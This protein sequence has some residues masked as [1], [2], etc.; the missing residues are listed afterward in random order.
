[1][2]K[3][4]RIDQPKGKQLDLLAKITGGKY[5]EL[6]IYLDCDPDDD[7][8]TQGGK[9]E[10]FDLSKVDGQFQ[11]MPIKG[12]RSVIMVTGPSGSGKSYFVAS[13]AKEYEKMNPDAPIFLFSEKPEDA[14]LDQIPNLIRVP[15]DE[16][17]IDKKIDMKK[18]EEM[19]DPT[20][21]IIFDDIDSLEKKEKKAIYEMIRKYLNIG[22][23]YNISII[24]T[25]HS[26][27]LGP[28]EREANRTLLNESHYYV[29]FPRSYDGS[30]EYVLD[31]YCG[32]GKHELNKVPSCKSRWMAIKKQAPR[33]IITEK[34]MYPIIYRSK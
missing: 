30:V 6:P 33:I 17:L 21:L 19:E 16:K 18:F 8:K 15:I 34:E 3:I 9:Y 28:A 5:N 12:K 10:K 25:N 24:V 7:L 4:F 31:K 22:R 27:S 20:M 26:P 23:K 1:M 11:V 14:V 32:M 13:Y 29:C 2:E